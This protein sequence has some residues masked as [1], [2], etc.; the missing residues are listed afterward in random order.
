LDPLI[1]K[2]MAGYVLSHQIM[3][4]G[5]GFYFYYDF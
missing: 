1:V 5:H 3:L 4:K 2:Q